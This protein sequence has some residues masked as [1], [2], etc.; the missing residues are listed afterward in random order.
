MSLT[1]PKSGMIVRVVHL[2]VPNQ[3]SSL[4][5]WHRAEIWAKKSRRFKLTMMV[6]AS[7]RAGTSLLLLRQT[8][9]GTKWTRSWTLKTP[10]LIR[11]LKRTLSFENASSRSDTSMPSSRMNTPGKRIQIPSLRTKSPGSGNQ[12]LISR[13]KS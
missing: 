2:K 9:S 7:I 10:P 3:L 1:K 12:M 4:K 8:F 5:Q 13:Q 11:S 6:I